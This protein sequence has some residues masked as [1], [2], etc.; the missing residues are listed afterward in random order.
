MTKRILAISI[1]SF[2]CILLSAQEVVFD[3]PEE[4]PKYDS[5]FSF[6]KNNLQY[7]PEAL[8]DSIEGSVLISFWIEQDGVTSGHE[9]MKGEREDMNA[10]AL[11]VAKM[12]KYDV[13]AMN[14]GMPVRHRTAIKIPFS[15]G[16]KQ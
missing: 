7:P 15:F 1:L 2:F 9:V 13:P 4:L 6:V 10:E 11:R 16:N 3:S 5:L 14:R 12:L 8:M